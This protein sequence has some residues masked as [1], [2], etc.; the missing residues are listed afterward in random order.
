M[1]KNA[2][3]KGYEYLAITDH[4]QRLRVANGLDPRRLRCQLDEIDRINESIDEMTV[5]KGIEVDILKD[6]R[7][8]LPN[9][10]LAELDLTVCSVHFVFN[11]S[12]EEQTERILR[13]MDNPYFK[14]L[15]TSIMTIRL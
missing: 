5:L 6:G 14:A 13:A 8:D 3:A 2:V 15:K 10:V 9:E 7:H 11:L 12:K 4:S 1:S